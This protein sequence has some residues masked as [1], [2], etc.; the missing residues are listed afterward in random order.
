MPPSQNESIPHVTQLCKDS[1]AVL[2]TPAN[3]YQPGEL[4]WDLNW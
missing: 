1:G 3:L 2:V 4:K